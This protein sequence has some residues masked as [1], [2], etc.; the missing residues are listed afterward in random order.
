M[1]CTARKFLSFFWRN[2]K[3]NE[4]VIFFCT[5][6]LYKFLTHIF[7]IVFYKKKKKKK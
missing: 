7:A 2:K 4:I 5:K 1:V 6:C 3:E